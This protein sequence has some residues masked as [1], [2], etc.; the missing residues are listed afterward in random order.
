MKIIDDNFMVCG[1]CLQALVNDDY[2][3]LD[4]YDEVIAEAR[5]QCILAGIDDLD[6]VAVLGDPDKDLEFSSSSCECCGISS[7][8]SR[9]QM[10]ILRN[11]PTPLS[12]RQY[13][14]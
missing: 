13:Y 2:T 12:T 6:G 9:H 1:E 10:V 7:G 3:G 4:L 14:I 11:D 8:G 5:M